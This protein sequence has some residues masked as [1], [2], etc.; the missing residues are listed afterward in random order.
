MN[1]RYEPKPSSGRGKSPDGKNQVDTKKK[2]K[3][4]SA[5]K[6]RKLGK[7]RKKTK[8][9]TKEGYSTLNLPIHVRAPILPYPSLPFLT[10]LAVPHI[11]FFFQSGSDESNCRPDCRISLKPSNICLRKSYLSDSVFGF[12][13]Q[14]LKVG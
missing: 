8:Q 6:G 1:P 5:G 10:S 3:K 7:I 4:K 11:H 14:Y 12:Q 9:Q 2:K 13:T